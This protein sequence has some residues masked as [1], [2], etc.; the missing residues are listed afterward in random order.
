MNPDDDASKLVD[1]QKIMNFSSEFE[2][3]LKEVM[4]ISESDKNDERLNNFADNVEVH[5]AVR[6]KR[7]ML[8]N[9]RQLI[10]RC[11]FTVPE[12]F[13]SKGPKFINNTYN[14]C[15][16]N[17]LFSSERCIVSLAACQLMKLVHQTLQRGTGLST[18]LNTSST[19]QMKSAEVLAE[20]LKNFRADN[21]VNN[22]EF[23][24]ESIVPEAGPWTI[25]GQVLKRARDPV[26]TPGAQ[27][28]LS[29]YF[30]NAFD[31][32]GGFKT[33]PLY[34]ILHEVIYCQG[35]PS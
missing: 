23:I 8:A 27:K 3:V 22:A 2:T 5:F 10:L 28:Q 6:K 17:L 15:A 16:V 26:I 1:F 34:A 25:L 9:A 11:D 35:V 24:R 33:N 31:N 7:E 4:F 29:Y 30:L 14:D 20:Y 32:W 21:I 18:P 12:E 13:S 19:R